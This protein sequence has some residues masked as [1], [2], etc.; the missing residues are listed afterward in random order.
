MTH[1]GQFADMMKVNLQLPF[2]LNVIPYHTV[3]QDTLQFTVLSNIYCE[4][5]YTFLANGIFQCRLG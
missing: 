5:K 3:N 4:K 2:V 1:K